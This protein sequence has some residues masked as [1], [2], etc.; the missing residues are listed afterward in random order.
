ML[1]AIKKGLSSQGRA[2]DNVSCFF[3]QAAMTES[4]AEIWVSG[5]HLRIIWILFG[6]E[7]KCLYE[8]LH[9]GCEYEEKEG[10]KHRTLRHPSDADDIE[11][12]ACDVR[13]SH[14][15]TVHVMPMSEREDMRIQCQ[16]H[17]GTLSNTSAPVKPSFIKNVLIFNIHLGHLYHQA[18]MLSAKNKT[19]TYTAHTVYYIRCCRNNFHTLNHCSSKKILHCN[20]MLGVSWWLALCGAHIHY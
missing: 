17:N 3:N 9:R 14:Q 20:V 18:Q 19:K 12:S 15:S 10:I 5:V 1:V 6:K 7:P 4:Q 13:L 8:C 2:A 16:L 11:L